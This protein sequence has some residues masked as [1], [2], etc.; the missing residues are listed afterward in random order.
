MTRSVDG[1]ICEVRED[2]FTDISQGSGLFNKI[3]SAIH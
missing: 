2:A 1:L 3:D